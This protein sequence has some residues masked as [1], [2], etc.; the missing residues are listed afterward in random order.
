MF[1]AINQSIA[2]AVHT[3]QAYVSTFKQGIQSGLSNI[4][5]S[6]QQLLTNQK[7]TTSPAVI[8]TLS[9]PATHLTTNDRPISLNVSEPEF[10]EVPATK[11]NAAKSRDLISRISDNTANVTLASIARE[12]LSS[13]DASREIRQSSVAVF[14]TLIEQYLLKHHLYVASEAGYTSVYHDLLKLLVMLK[15]NITELKDKPEFVTVYEHL[16]GNQPFDTP[17]D[18][19]KYQLLIQKQETLLTRFTEDLEDRSDGW[20]RWEVS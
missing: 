1:N 3:I 12:A 14:N 4:Y 6:V 7:S 20:K 10:P 11:L 5:Q 8:P 9:L 18:Q 15:D 13:F 17:E 2:S 16:Q 19:E